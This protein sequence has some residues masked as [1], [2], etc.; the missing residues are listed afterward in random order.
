M[1]KTGMWNW[2]ASSGLVF[3][4]PQFWAIFGID[5]QREGV[6]P[7][8]LLR[9]I[10]KQD[11]IRIVRAFKKAIRMSQP[12]TLELQIAGGR[13]GVTDAVATMRIDADL[14]GRLVGSFG[15]FQDIS[16]RK[17]AEQ[18]GSQNRSLTESLRIAQDLADQQ[19]SF[20]SMVA[21][22]IRTPLAIIDGHAHRLQRVPAHSASG[23]SPDA[24][25][26]IRSS[27]KRLTGVI[28]KVLCAARFEAGRTPYAP[29]WL[30]LAGLLEDICES[31]LEI[32]PS[33]RIEQDFDR[34]QDKIFGDRKLLDHVFTNLISNALKYSPESEQIWVSAR[35]DDDGV[36]ISVRDQ[37]VGIPEDEL[38]SIYERFFRARTSTGIV[39]TGYGL[40]IVKQFIE[41]HHGRIDLTSREGEGST[42]SVRLPRQ[43]PNPDA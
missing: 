10:L 5:D 8:A 6:P 7:S 42:F 32:M 3:G 2:R 23:G 24:A 30:D 26:K 34:L 41:L 39:G 20:V 38:A 17:Q 15:I 18:L 12:L 13:C 40:H 27:V 29:A 16:D 22:E 11:R 4:S 35:Q 36:E 28:D 37:G 1:S 31:Q 21:H 43:A 9:R 19:R 14:T 25:N 33:R